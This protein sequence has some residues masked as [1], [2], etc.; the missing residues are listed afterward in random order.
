MKSEKSR[1]KNEKLNSKTK[2]TLIMKGGIS[3]EESEEVLPAC[4][5]KSVLCSL[6]EGAYLLSIIYDTSQK[7]C[8][9]N[10]SQKN[11]TMD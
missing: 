9:L 11:I 1:G 5:K 3:D 10:L 2:A 8:C 7:K 6:Q 4:A